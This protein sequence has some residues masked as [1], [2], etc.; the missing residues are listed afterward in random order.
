M[1]SKKGMEH[2]NDRMLSDEKNSR[3]EEKTDDDSFIDSE[4]ASAQPSA[5]SAEIGSEFESDDSDKPEEKEL[6]PE[7]ELKSRD[8]YDFEKLT[9]DTSS[10]EDIFD[11]GKLDQE[12]LADNV[13][14]Y[15]DALDGLDEEDEDDDDDFFA[16]NSFGSDSSRGPS[17]DNMDNMFSPEDI[18]PQKKNDTPFEL[19]DGLDELQNDYQKKK[20][21]PRPQYRDPY[22]NKQPEE[23]A[24]ERP[25]DMA[26][27]QPQPPQQ[28][29]PQLPSQD[30]AYEQKR[31]EELQKLQD[32]AKELQNAKQELAEQQRQNQERD[33][34]RL[35]KY[36]DDQTDKRNEELKKLQDLAKELQDAKKQLQE[37]A[38]KQN[39]LPENRKEPEQKPEEP[40]QKP[41]PLPEPEPE[42]EFDPEP[43]QLRKPEP[44]PESE[45]EPLYEE[46]SAPGEAVEP[47]LSEDELEGAADEFDYN[48]SLPQNEATEY[49]PDENI[50]DDE[51]ILRKSDSPDS[52]MPENDMDSPYEEPMFSDEDELRDAY[53]MMKEDP[54]ENEIEEVLPAENEEALP[55]E[56]GDPEVE[57]ESEPEPAASEETETEAEP[58]SE[59]ESDAGAEPEEQDIDSLAHEIASESDDDEELDWPAITPEELAFAESQPAV[60]PEEDAYEMAAD[61]MRRVVDE[62]TEYETTQK[63]SLTSK[64]FQNLKAF[65]QFLPDGKSDAFLR[66]RTNLQLE[67]IIA[68]RSGKR[69][70]LAQASAIRDQL[71]DDDISGVNFDKKKLALTILNSMLP[72]VYELPDKEKSGKLEKEV[73]RMFEKITN[74]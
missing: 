11:S 69:G 10:I 8:P 3:Q 2:I 23:P 9:D 37:A 73:E 52:I 25:Q 50:M 6:T 22:E 46:P 45:P 33:L 24:Y 51:D 5:D 12:I 18:M 29:Q 15:D 61:T 66:S 28:P 38:E 31:N 47:L 54:D 67:F 74:T 14:K 20:E 48:Q 43:E 16:N 26:Q 49:E 13:G 63:F 57:L 36:E 64:L 34:E 7:E 21:P 58:E 55:S 17:E 42:P 4:L 30:D 32:L 60:R 70:L 56:A 59:P 39:G 40:V 72:L 35:K 68:R 62:L 44:E 71:G 1:A 53:D 41:E 19:S 27:P 65:S